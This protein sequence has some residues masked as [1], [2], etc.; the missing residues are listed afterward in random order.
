[1]A[2][3]SERKDG[4]AAFP[5]VDNGIVYEGGGPFLRAS[6]RGMTLRDYFAAQVL[7]GLCAGGSWDDIPTN[8][9]LVNISYEL[10]AAMLERRAK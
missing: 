6:D 4:G 8:D 3:K 5:Q 10:A 9:R 7:A 2:T 1:M